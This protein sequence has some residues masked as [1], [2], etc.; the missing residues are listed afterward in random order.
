[1]IYCNCGLKDERNSRSILY[2]DVNNGTFSSFRRQK[3]VWWNMH[4]STNQCGGVWRSP[5]SSY[6]P[7]T[8]TANNPLTSRHR[9]TGSYRIC[10]HG[11]FSPK[12][13]LSEFPRVELALRWSTKKHIGSQDHAMYTRPDPS[14]LILGYILKCFLYPCVGRHGAAYFPLFSTIFTKILNLWFF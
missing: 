12:V 9:S 14:N 11:G 10:L 6:N 1:M 8:R 13:L 5:H 2:R 3:G 7:L 4:K